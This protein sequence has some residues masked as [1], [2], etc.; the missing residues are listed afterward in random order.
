MNSDSIAFLRIENIVQGKVEG[1]SIEDAIPLGIEAVNIGRPSKDSNTPSPDIKIAGDD[2]ISRN[3]AEIRYSVEDDCFVLSDLG[4][5]NGTFLNGELIEQNRPYKLTDY[6]LIGF[7][8]VGSQMRANLRFRRTEQTLPSWLIKDVR[9]SMEKGGLY[10]HISSRRVL[11]DNCEVA[12]TGKE[13]KVL[14]YLYNNRGN[15]CTTDDISWEIW[16][17]EGASDELVAKYISLL[18][19]KL[20]KDPSNP[21]YIITVPGRQGCYRLEI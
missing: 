19:K 5:R 3:Q 1:Y 7:A 20:E 6:D 12:L 13:F 15:A 4:S 10:I 17:R 11:V 14:E 16:G 2:Y 18:R 9:K 8:K 21:K